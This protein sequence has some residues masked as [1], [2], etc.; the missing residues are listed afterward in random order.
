M[1]EPLSALKKQCVG[2]RHGAAGN[3]GVTLGTFTIDS[4]WQI[5]GW[6][7]FEN[8]AASALMSLGLGGLGNYRQSQSAGTVTSFRIA[9]D[10]L[11]LKGCGDLSA[12]TTPDLMVL[13]L[14][15][16]RTAI[17]LEGPTARD[18]LAQVIPVDT[19]AHAFGLGE[20]LQT[21]I[22]QVGVLIHCTGDNSFEILVPCTWAVSVWEV[23]VENAYS[24]G[25][26]VRGAA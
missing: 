19:S 26:T 17:A 12:R 9:P 6:D 11:L 3:A 2:G 14:S 25:L 16:S 1:V 5:A 23:L 22:H 10:K 4:L 7:G 8:A 20:F 24:H 21:G 15:H 18:L 13:D